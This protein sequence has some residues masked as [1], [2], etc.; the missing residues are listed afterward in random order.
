[1]YKNAGLIRRKKYTLEN[2]CENSEDG[3]SVAFPVKHSVRPNCAEHSLPGVSFPWPGLLP[4]T[5][6]VPSSLT[7]SSQEAKG[8]AA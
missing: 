5:H 4:V 8:K 3:G 7:F 2:V 6:L 1:M